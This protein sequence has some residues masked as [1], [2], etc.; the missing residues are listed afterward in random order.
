MALI[1]RL[2][3]INKKEYSQ[4]VIKGWKGDYD[5]KPHER[6]ST[7]DTSRKENPGQENEYQTVQSIPIR[8]I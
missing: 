1:T 7:A 8:Q 3:S 2:G 6:E 4:M 5:C